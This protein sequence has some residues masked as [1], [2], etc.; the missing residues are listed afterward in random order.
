MPPPAAHSTFA[1]V[2]GEYG[3]FCYH[4]M[5]LQADAAAC[6][7]ATGY[8]FGCALITTELTVDLHW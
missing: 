1:A 8:F 3:K 7:S 5:L 2:E 6:K 4:R